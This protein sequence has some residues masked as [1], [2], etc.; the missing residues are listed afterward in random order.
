VY[1]PE[2]GTTETEIDLPPESEWDQ[3]APPPKKDD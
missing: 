2:S 1:V 3:V